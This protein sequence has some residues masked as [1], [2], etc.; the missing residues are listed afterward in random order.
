MTRPWQIGGLFGLCLLMVI[1]AMSWVSW[2]ALQLDL[3]Q[4]RARRQAVFEEDVRLALW[5]MDSALAPLIA[6]ENSRPYFAWY[7]W[8]PASRPYSNMF[9]QTTQ[10]E[11]LIASPLVTQKAPEVLLY[12]QIDPAGRVSSPQIPLHQQQALPTPQQQQQA[13]QMQPQPRPVQPDVWERRLARIKPWLNFESL[14]AA[15]PAEPAQP[16]ETLAQTPTASPRG[17]GDYFSRA[18]VSAAEYEARLRN[19]QMALQ[20][21]AP[22]V[23]VQ[24]IAPDIEPVPAPMPAEA[25][26]VAIGLMKPLWIGNE[27]VLARQVAVAGQPYVQGCWLDWPRIRKS[28]LADV[29]D[30]LPRAAL[31]PYPHD[32][33]RAQRSRLLAA[34]PVRLVP[35]ELPDE[36]IA[37]TA[38]VRLTLVLAWGCLLLAGVAVAVL[39]A[40]TLRL[41]E[42]RAAFVSSVTHEL[43]TPLTTLRMYAEMLAAG[44]VSDPAKRQHYLQTLHRE[45]DRLGGLVENVLTYARLERGR[46]RR[47]VET[48]SLRQLLD[49]VAQRLSSRA[50]QAGMHLEALA[51]EPARTTL[52]RVDLTAVE[53]ILFNLVDNACKYAVSAKDCRIELAAG[54]DG[55]LAFLAVR[56]HGPGIPPAGARRLFRPFHKSASD[57]AE[58]APGVGLGLALCHRL[59]REMKGRLRLDPTAEGGARFVLTLPIAS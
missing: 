4:T 41:S 20:Q 24:Q 10:G 49:R 58:T 18:G 44:M 35:D 36:P 1:A 19:T 17:K 52:V 21:N 45:A 42:R 25:N 39:L 2:T 43:R 7:A 11:P 29:A 23:A 51:D 32:P 33:K 54:V 59:A 9:R 38:T 5:R 37:V 8:Y 56:D 46:V 22:P 30:V 50:E 12:F 31:L 55:G 27:L 13:A 57:A 26:S 15:L 28:L 47:Q 34:L 16:V 48:I 53:Q 40:G 3:A 14:L 6:R